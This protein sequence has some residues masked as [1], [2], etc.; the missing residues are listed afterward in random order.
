M[1][2]LVLSIHIGLVFWCAQLTAAE[3]SPPKR[4]PTFGFGRAG[5]GRGFR[6]L[7]VAAGGS[8]STA[9]AL[10]P[11]LSPGAGRSS[12]TC[13]INE[14]DLV[15]SHTL[16]SGNFGY[17]HKGE[18]TTPAGIKVRHWVRLRATRKAEL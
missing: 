3:M 14:R 8:S 5:S 18:W 4:L 10:D 15:L 17:V 13:L 1:L 9:A 12:L 16:G 11:A 6:A 7:D 2:L